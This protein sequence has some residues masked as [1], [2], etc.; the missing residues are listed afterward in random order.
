MKFNY[1]TFSCS[2]SPYPHP[3]ET[4]YDRNITI[5][6]SQNQVMSFCLNP[7]CQRP[8]NPQ[9]SNFCLHCGNSLRLGDRYRAI[10][11]IATGGFSRTFLGV[12]EQTPSQ[13]YCVIK[14]FYPEKGSNN[15]QKAVALFQAEAE[16]L[17]T[18]GNHPQIPQL[19]AYFAETNPQYLVQEF[20][21]GVDLE[22]EVKHNGA[23][24]EAQIRQILHS[25]LPVLDFIHQKQ[26][27]HRDIKPANIIRRR[28]DGELVLV[29]FGAAKMLTGV[30]LAQ[31]GTSIGS[32]GYAAPEQIL[33]KASYA[34]DLYALGVTCV[35]LLTDIPT[36]DLFDSQEDTWVWQDYLV[37]NQISASFSGIL[38]KMLARAISQRYDSAQQILADLKK[39]NSPPTRSQDGHSLA[40]EFPVSQQVQQT[41]LQLQNTPRLKITY[42]LWGVSLI[43]GSIAHPLRGLHRFYNGKFVTG[44][45]WMLPL[46]GE[47]GLILDLFLIPRMVEEYESKTK[48]KFG[49]S[50]RGVP[51]QNSA[52]ITETIAPPTREELKLKVLQAAKKRNGVI[53][54][55]QAAVDTQISLHEV[56]MLL[57]E[58]ETDGYAE[59]G[60]DG[61]T[62]TVLYW[63]HNV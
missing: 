49:L 41:I 9:D 31:T 45:L 26:V 20:V 34:S 46:V 6:P 29:D 62:G 25:L 55:A 22:T 39:H 21:D 57:R 51:L 17:E 52:A 33:G 12:D 53:S 4:R 23:F 8:H 48:A 2:R 11:P 3:T 60:N 1:S 32:A 56:E 30:S 50:S 18:L 42:F 37:E 28:E 10:K 43:A 58:L 7:S 5:A 35:R 44:L 19:L 13:K 16:R 61:E 14:Q 36:F 15:S 47:V 54:V 38:D 27:V 63:F 24:N 40:S 59:M